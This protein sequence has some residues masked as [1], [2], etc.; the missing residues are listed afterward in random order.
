VG[1]RKPLAK[2]SSQ[3]IENDHEIVPSAQ[4]GSIL[5]RQMLDGV[6]EADSKESHRP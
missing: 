2:W 6:K 5:Q 4:Q 3:A 1:K